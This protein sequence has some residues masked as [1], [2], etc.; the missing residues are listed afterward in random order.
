MNALMWLF[1]RGRARLFGGIAED[2]VA[3]D[4]LTIVDQNVA[5]WFHVRRTP[6]LTTAMQLVTTLLYRA[7]RF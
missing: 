3:G 2:V 7:A 6:G 4:P 1:A 5:E